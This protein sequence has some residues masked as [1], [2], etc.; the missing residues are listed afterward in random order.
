MKTAHRSHPHLAITL[1]IGSALLAGASS[2]QAQIKRWVDERGM[3][4][5]GDAAPQARPAGAVTSVAPTEPLTP[6][7]QAAAAQRLQKYRDQLAEPPQ[8]PASAASSPAARG[9]PTGNSCADQ[10]A[11]YNA[12]YAC[13]DRY[14]MT[15]GG[16]RPEAFDKCPV[17]AQPS[18]PAPGSQ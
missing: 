15:R 12:A 9:L 4:H 6:A 14:R 7:E 2:A 13:M 11:R 17:V 16:I 10:W 18:C 8:A 5:Y 1:L 3:V